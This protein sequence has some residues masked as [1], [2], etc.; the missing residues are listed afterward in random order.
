M[1]SVAVIIG[2][3]IVGKV[4]TTMGRKFILVGGLCSMGLSMIGFGLTP[5]APSLSLFTILAF[6]FRF[7][8]GWSS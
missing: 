3:P 4:M 8:Q 5:L 1:Y 2:S 6:I 7:L